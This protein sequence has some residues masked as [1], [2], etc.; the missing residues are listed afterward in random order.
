MFR[1]GPCQVT[2]FT[3]RPSASV[4][5]YGVAAPTPSAP[6]QKAQLNPPSAVVANIFSPRCTNLRFMSAT[7][8]SCR[9]GSWSQ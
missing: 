7:A 5:V 6:W 4:M 8:F 1:A 2:S 3:N 9:P